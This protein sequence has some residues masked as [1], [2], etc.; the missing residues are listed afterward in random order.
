MSQ[1][2]F[3]C[4]DSSLVNQEKQKIGH[5]GK[6][7]IKLNLKHNFLPYGNWNIETL[8]IFCKKWDLKNCDFDRVGPG[9]LSP[10]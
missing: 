7:A 10:S 5:I 6:A 1:H 2:Y 9:K 8:L 4:P 3:P